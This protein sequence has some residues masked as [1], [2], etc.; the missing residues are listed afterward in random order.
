MR[1][2][3]YRYIEMICG[4]LVEAFEYVK[5]S[6]NY[7]V[8]ADC[9]EAMTAISNVISSQ[10]GESF[11]KIKSIL[12]DMFKI[13]EIL[14]KPE[15]D[16]PKLVQLSKSLFSQ[17]KNG[18][19]YKLRILFVAEL[20]SKWDSM[21]SVYK[22][23]LERDD[24][25]VDV[26]LEPIFRVTKLSNGATKSEI[27][28]EDWLTPLGIKHIPYTQYDMETIQPDITFISQPYESVTIPMFWPENIAKYSKLVYLPYYTA[29][30]IDTESVFESFFKMPVQKCAWK[31]VCQTD[32]MK[33]M[34]EL[35]AS[36]KGKNVVVTGLPKWDYPMNLDKQSVPCPDEWKEKFNGRKV[37]LLNTHFGVTFRLPEEDNTAVLP[38]LLSRKDISFVWR[39]HPMT[40]IVAKLYSPQNYEKYK[41]LEQMVE[42]SPNGVLDKRTSYAEAFLYTDAL[43]STPGSLI[44]QYLLMRKPVLNLYYIDTS[45]ALFDFN[46]LRVSNGVADI[47]KFIADVNDG[48][49]F[50]NDIDILL[51][52]YFNLANGKIGNRVVEV[53]LSDFEKEM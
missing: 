15:K 13:I 37:F 33:D 8:L 47:D 7:G 38:Y 12:S 3:Q 20:G 32:A 36:E 30:S 18:I 25:E 48:F 49:D 24:C 39:P 28:Y 52:K 50:D 14:D 21:E 19:T 17:L 42:E 9:I 5:V 35:Y 46:C 45:D 41:A 53:I 43:I 27:I 16:I 29:T 44:Q 1:Y 10:S 26:V 40:E 6:K 51:K 34:Y 22:A 31:I 11:D 23:F 2:I 4:S